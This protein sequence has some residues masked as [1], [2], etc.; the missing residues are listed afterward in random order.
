MNL[1]P[2]AGGVDRVLDRLVVPGFSRV[3]PAVRRRLPSWPAD[4]RPD[5]LAGKHV[6]I[7]GATSGIGTA[8]A[9]QLADLGAHVHLL[10]RDEAKGARLAREIGSDATVWRCDVGDL[11]SVRVFATSFGDQ[12]IPIHALIHNA[13]VLPAERTESAQGH[14]LTMAVHVL[15]PVLMTDLLAARLTDDARVILVTSGGM[16]TQS[17]P[18]ADPDYR[19]GTYSGAT[20]YARSKRTQVELLDRLGRRWP[21]AAVYATHPGWVAT[22]GVSQSLPTFEKVMGPLLRDADEGADTTTWLAAISPRPEGG[23]LWHD[24][25]MRPTVVVPGTRATP[26]DREQMWSWVAEAAGLLSN[27]GESNPSQTGTS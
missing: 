24:R 14:E 8:T 21:Q 1:A 12:S 5:A 13:G 10:V 20:A 6:L 19:E 25:R 7:S 2:L 9:Q 17:L 3:G 4:P 16:Y 22:P 27:P 23:G 11:D 15:G 26:T 18:V